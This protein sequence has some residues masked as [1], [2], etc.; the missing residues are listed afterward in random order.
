LIAAVVELP[1][2][3]GCRLIGNVV[4]AQPD[5]VAIGLPVRVDWYDVATDTTVPVFRLV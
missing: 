1:G 2:T 4:D 5:A 3:D